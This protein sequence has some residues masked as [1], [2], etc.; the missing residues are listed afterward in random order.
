M[1]IRDEAIAYLASIRN[2]YNNERIDLR[3]LSISKTAERMKKY[4]P[5][6][7]E[8][9]LDKDTLFELFFGHL[10][11]E[12]IFSLK[13]VHL[14][15][16]PGAWIIKSGKR[17]GRMY[18]VLTLLKSKTSKD[19]AIKMTEEVGVVYDRDRTEIKELVVPTGEL[20]FTNFFLDIDSEYAFDLSEE[21]KY[22]EKYSI[23]NVY[24][25]QNC[26]N[27]LAKHHNL[28]Y[29]QLGNT[30]CE[31][32]KVNENRI[33]LC[34]VYYDETEVPYGWE[35]L[36]SISCDVWRIEFIDQL[37]IDK[38]KTISRKRLEEEDKVTVSVTPGKWQI[39]NY[40]HRKSD[41]KLAE[42]FGYPV[43]VELNRIKD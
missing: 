10:K 36:G 29:V 16:E 35:S 4:I 1:N 19:D 26:M 33:H 2:T 17:G 39:K 32:F 43:W 23:N 38:N 7:E 6:I 40:Y 12:L 34:P 41:K 13:H 25:R 9:G 15:D 30:S 14:F 11:I 27:Y 37:F 21:L 22:T 18:E 28:G 42:D 8:G 31:V 20:V 24:G 5:K 3:M